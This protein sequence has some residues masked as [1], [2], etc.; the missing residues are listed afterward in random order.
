M[1]V[2][3]QQ[4]RVV[5]IVIRVVIEIT[6]LTFQPSKFIIENFKAELLSLNA[7]F[8]VIHPRNFAN[9]RD[10]PQGNATVSSI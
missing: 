2:Y 7:T 5:N 10:G 4:Q 6:P 3:V 9:H 8:G 1:H